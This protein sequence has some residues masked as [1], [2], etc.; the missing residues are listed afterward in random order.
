MANDRQSDNGAVVAI[1]VGLAIVVLL[2]VV[3][4]G[5][6][7]LFALGT[8]QVAVQV[9]ATTPPTVASDPS[10]VL[11]ADADPLSNA[12]NASTLNIEAT[13]D[14]KL[15]VNGNETTLEKLKESL[16]ARKESGTS[17]QVQLRA[18]DSGASALHEPLVELLKSLEIE[19]VIKDE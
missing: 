2:G 8:R 10:P 5:V 7:L 19:F 11:P 3:S 9:Q 13:K 12:L 6:A 4:L 15:L 18:S 16:Q 14:G 1:V 17:P